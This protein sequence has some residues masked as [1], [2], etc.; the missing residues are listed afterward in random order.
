MHTVVP[1]APSRKSLALSA[2]LF[3][4]PLALAQGVMIFLSVW[5]ESGGTPWLFGTAVCSVLGGGL[6]AFRTTRGVDESTSANWGRLSGLLT[7]L[8]SSLLGLFILALMIIWYIT[9]W[10]PSLSTQ[11][12]P[13]HV[14]PLSCMSPQ[15]GAKFG[16]IF[17]PFEILFFLLGN[18]GFVL[19]ALLGGT[20]AAHLRAHHIPMKQR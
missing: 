14:T 8:F 1:P 12:S 5:A 2:L 9:W 16:L 10:I 19:L 7:G 15:A 4:V 13:C 20:L 18:V 11:P 17:L 6:C 3:A